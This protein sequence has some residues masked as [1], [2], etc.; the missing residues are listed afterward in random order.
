[1]IVITGAAGFIGSCMAQKMNESGRKDLILVDDFTKE[2]K[3]RNWVGKQYA[4]K[5]DRN[6]FYQSLI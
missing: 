5:I 6:D 4:D 3:K 2:Q 1:M